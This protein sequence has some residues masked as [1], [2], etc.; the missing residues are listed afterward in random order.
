[1]RIAKS[2]IM[3]IASKYSIPIIEV[4]A[5]NK[6]FSSIDDY[7]ILISK[8]EKLS[9]E[10]IHVRYDL[11]EEQ[12]NTS[13]IANLLFEIEPN[14]RPDAKSRRIIIDR[15]NMMSKKI[16]HIAFGNGKNTI[17]ESAITFLMYAAGISNYSVHENRQEAIVAL[18]E[19][20]K[21]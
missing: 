11:L 13:G 9:P 19:L 5:V 21:C 2:T 12:I 17:S 8:L 7:I 6:G 10:L 20:T 16:K 15:L 18:D 3:R 14:R 1:M 4:E